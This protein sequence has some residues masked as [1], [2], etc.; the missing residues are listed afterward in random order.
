MNAEIVTGVI[1][2]VGCSRWLWL[3]LLA[4]W[5]FTVMVLI[6]IIEKCKKQQEHI[7]RQRKTIVRLKYGKKK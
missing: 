4:L 7:I 3:P 6:I 2:E 1:G 5:I